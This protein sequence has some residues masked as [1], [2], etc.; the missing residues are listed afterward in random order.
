MIAKGNTHDSG[1]RLARYLTRGK[2]D[3]YA[4]LWGLRGFASREITEAFRT[5]QVMAAGSRCQQPFFH[6]QVRNRDG[7]TL[8]RS[9]WETVADRIERTLGLRDQP[10]AIA[11]H[12]DRRTGH[13]HL[14]V[15]WSRIN[16]DTLRA[17]PL[18]FYKLRLKTVARELEVEL[19]LTPVKNQRADSINYAPTRAQDA[20]ARRLGVDIHVIRQAI[21][22]CFERSDCGRSFQ[23][24]LALQGLTLAR[25]D[26]RDHIVVD[27]G[28]GLHAVGKRILGVSAAQTR[29]RLADLCPDQLPNLQQARKQALKSLGGREKKARP[30]RGTRT[31]TLRE[32]S[33]PIGIGKDIIASTMFERFNA[34]EGGLLSEQDHATLPLVPVL[35]TE[36]VA[37]GIGR[38]EL[39]EGSEKRN[40]EQFRQL[41]QPISPPAPEEKSPR[42]GSRI[43]QEFRRL[44]RLLTGRG[45]ELQPKPRRRRSGEKSGTFVAAARTLFRRAS[46]H[47]ILGFLTPQWDAFTWLRIWDHSNHASIRSYAASDQEPQHGSDLSPR[48]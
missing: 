18:P 29:Q 35:R 10:R 42:L 19:G 34:E 45:P 38:P 41:E 22:D 15:A 48:I 5:V 40:G 27:R 44:V 36:P 30:R 16:E 47:T 25:G 6:V 31:T 3:E 8:S 14:H 33:A 9:Q 4:E 12:I 39:S 2:Q 26:R 20:Q 43:R 37:P 7:E 23:A 11:V 24:A 17:A 13:E 21:L 1:V 32:T 46:E 28:G